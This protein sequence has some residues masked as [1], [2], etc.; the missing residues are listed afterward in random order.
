MVWC[1]GAAPGGFSGGAGVWGLGWVFVSGWGAL[2]VWAVWG[3]VGGWLGGVGLFGG[4]RAVP[5]VG[6][7]GFCLARGGGFGLG[8]V[9]PLDPSVGG[10]WGRLGVGL[11]LVGGLGGGRGGGFAGWW[12]GLASGGTTYETPR[13]RQGPERKQQRQTPPTAPTPKKATVARQ[14]THPW[15]PPLPH[16]PLE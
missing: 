6:W 10:L 13:L 2:G 4:G 15:G 3:F 14:Q 8:G 1:G 9:D 12:L 11:G 7:V 5:F 16:S